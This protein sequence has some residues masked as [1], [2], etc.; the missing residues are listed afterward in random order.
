VVDTRDGRPE[1]SGIPVRTSLQK[2]VVATTAVSL[3]AGVGASVARADRPDLT[4]TTFCHH[5]GTNA[6]E[7][8]TL[9]RV[10]WENG[11]QQHGDTLG[12]CEGDEDPGGEDP[13]GE[14]PGGEDPGSEDPDGG[15]E[16]FIAHLTGILPGDLVALL[17]VGA[18]ASVDDI[19]AALALLE[20]GVGI[21]LDAILVEVTDGACNVIDL[22]FHIKHK[23]L[24]V[25]FFTTGGV[26]HLAG[27]VT[28]TALHV[29][30]H[31]VEHATG[32]AISGVVVGLDAAVYNLF[33]V[34]ADVSAGLFVGL[35]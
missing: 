29:V 20:V 14:D 8:K 23:L 31:V 7:T 21:D 19:V 16:A 4:P 22:A 32:D 2:T 26:L 35:L 28:H 6:E 17:G 11:H 9:P 15:C 13:G 18:Y 33:G 30:D 24:G 34:S 10:A 1:K 5:P 27:H 12:P 3:L 25:V